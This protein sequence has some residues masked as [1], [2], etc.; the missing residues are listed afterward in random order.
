M[1]KL[2]QQRYKPDT[3]KCSMIVEFDRDNPSEW[4]LVKMETQCSA[5]ADMD[6]KE[7][8]DCIVGDTENSEQRRKNFFLRDVIEDADADVAVEE[9]VRLREIDPATN[10]WKTRS[11][12]KLC[13]DVEYHWRFRGK[14]KDRTLEV[15]FVGCEETSARKA[16]MDRIAKRRKNVVVKP[17]AEFFSG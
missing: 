11:V 1:S 6:E 16:G 12:K 4:R 9:T 2:S 5:H 15:T 8:Y 14:G 17:A 3:C 7:A 10:G 13:P